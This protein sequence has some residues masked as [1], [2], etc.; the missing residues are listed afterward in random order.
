MYLNHKVTNVFLNIIN[1]LIIILILSPAAYSREVI[2]WVENVGVSPLNVIVKAKIDTGADSSSLHCDCIN[3]FMRDGE[4]WISFMLTDVDGKQVVVE[5]KLLRKVK[6]KRHF[7]DAQ[8]RDVIRLG[9]CIGSH[10]EETDVSLVDRTGLN[11]SMLIGRKFL[12]G[13]FLVDP[14]ATFATSPNCR[15]VE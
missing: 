13:N 8:R 6:V 7:G 4:S 14:S 3:K 5:K 11:Y 12:R 9:V 15:E 10:Y 2:G 1:G